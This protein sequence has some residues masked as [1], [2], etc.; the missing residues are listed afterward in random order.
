M[1]LNEDVL[2]VGPVDLFGGYLQLY[3][4]GVREIAWQDRDMS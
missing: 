2:K 3:T 1:T 4:F